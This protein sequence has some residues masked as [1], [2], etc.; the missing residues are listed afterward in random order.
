M[1]FALALQKRTEQTTFT[2][3]CIPA[4]T[5]HKAHAR[6]SQAQ[7]AGMSQCRGARGERPVGS[8]V[9]RTCGNGCVST[10]ASTDAGE[11][12]AR[13]IA[14]MARRPRAFRRC[15]VPRHWNQIR[16]VVSRSSTVLPLTSAQC[17]HRQT[18]CR[19]SFPLYA[20]TLG[21]SARRRLWRWLRSL[22]HAR[23]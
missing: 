2:G 4:S 12:A 15:E 9:C 14:G 22:C 1:A 8:T 11:F 18:A 21:T 23:R 7:A 16:G 17:T 13:G 20:C 3:S 19:T 6:A 10:S 5:A